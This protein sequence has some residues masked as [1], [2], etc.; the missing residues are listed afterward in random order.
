VIGERV[1]DKIAASK[2][3]G[4]FMGGNIP[5]GYTNRD[6]K[7]VVVP[8]EAE[9]V[10]WIFQRYLELG[11]IGRLLEE[12][13]RLGIRTKVQILS[14]GKRRGGVQFGKG[15]LAYLLKNR[16]YVA[17]ILHRG[18]IHPADH[19]PVIAKE[20]FDAVQANLNANAI[21]RRT[22]SKATPFLLAG[23]LFDSAGNRMTPSH[24]CKKGVR[25]RYYVSQAVLQSRKAEAG[26]VSR[27]P[28]PEIEAL[29]E[30]LVRD[31]CRNWLGDLRSLVEVQ[32]SR[33]TVQP[34]SISVELVGPAGTPGDPA[35]SS[36][37]IVSLPWSKKP[38]RV[39]KGVAAD[40]SA[41]APGQET[42]PQA[43]DGVLAAI[44]RAR[45]WVDALVTGD[46]LE[47]VAKREGTSARYMRQLIPLAFVPPKELREIADGRVQQTLTE[48]AKGVPLFWIV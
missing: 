41:P 34:D 26:K 22:R 24:S 14:T 47:D 28:A 38:F 13:N 36:P 17:E 42:D 23:L 8:E 31:R 7:L 43:R 9:R 46:N 10:R 6:K 37:H 19:E 15:T 1:R 45:Q 29:I 27:L 5:L 30:R 21:D 48:L 35:A 4:L 44:G 11:S 39:D 40:P 3:K 32:V 25:Y 2:R 20:T 33:I 16:C 12:M 18:Q